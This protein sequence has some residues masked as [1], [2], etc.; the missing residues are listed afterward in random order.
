MKKIFALG[1]CFILIGI[2]FASPLPPIPVPPNTSAWHI[3]IIFNAPNSSVKTVT[4]GICEFTSA[5]TQHRAVV[6]PPPFYTENIAG[7]KYINVFIPKDLLDV[8]GNVITHYTANV[9]QIKSKALAWMS[10]W[11]VSCGMD[12]SK[13][14]NAILLNENE[15]ALTCEAGIFSFLAK[16]NANNSAISPVAIKNP[17]NT[18]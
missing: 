15:T 13:N 17:L 5:D 12:I 8:Q 3:G 10:G 2:N 7:G 1:V 9:T 18:R 4:Y 6:C 14:L 16:S 11:G